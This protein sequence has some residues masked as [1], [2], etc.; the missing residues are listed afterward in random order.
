MSSFTVTLMMVLC[1]LFFTFQGFFG[2][3]YAI[4]Y[5]GKEQNATPVFSSLYGLLVG[6]VTL[7]V[8]SRF[9]FSASTATWLLGLLNGFILFLFNLSTVNASRTGPYTLQS[10]LTYSG[11]VVIVLLVS[12]L[13]WRDTLYCYQFVG[14]AVM[15]LSFIVI[16]WQNTTFVIKKKS[17]FV[18]VSMLFLSNGFYGV[19]MDAQ[20]RIMQ[21]AESNEMIII[22]FFASAVISLAYLLL[23]QKKECLRAFS[24]EKKVWLYI[25]LASASAAAGVNS[26]MMMLSKINSSIYF[27][28]ENGAVL[29]LTILLGHFV[30]K[31]KI[32][33]RMVVGILLCIVSL[34]LLAL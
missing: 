34:T 27:T 10:M 26:M 8:G 23:T 13:F 17:Y 15:I 22:T 30:L 25:A 6:F 9:A 28:I 19:I 12:T 5:R 3:M 32:T 14:I 33:R 7:A 20:Q 2:K 29:A 24:M 31:E 16:N 4:S 21:Q 11:N 1:I 18:W